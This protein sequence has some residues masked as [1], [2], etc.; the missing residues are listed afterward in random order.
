MKM[1]RYG[2]FILVL[3]CCL[4]TGCGRSKNENLDTE[5]ALASN[6]ENET[7]EGEQ[8]NLVDSDH[9]SSDDQTEDSEISGVEVEQEPLS[10]EE[11]IRQDIIE[12]SLLAEGNNYR[13][14]KVIEK[15]RNGE[16]IT[17]A[18]IGG[19]ITEGYNAGTQEIYA[20]L[21]CDYFR[22]TYATAEVTY[23][24]AGLSGTPSLLGLIRS[25]RDIFTYEPDL[26]FIEFAVND[27]QSVQDI[28]AYESLVR[29]ALSQEQEPA[30]IL[31]FSVIESGYTCQDTMQVVGFNYK[32]PMISVK[33]ALDPEFEAGR[34][35]WS[36]WS[37][38]ESHPNTFG[39]EL[40]SEFI[41]HYWNTVDQEEYDETYQL[42]DDMINMDYT[43]MIMA[44]KENLSVESTGAFHEESGHAAFPNGWVKAAEDTTEEAFT[45]EINCK[46][47][48]LVYKAANNSEYGDA[49][50]YVDGEL[51]ITISANAADGWNNPVVARI[52]RESESKTRKIE[53]RMKEGDEGK[54]FAILAFGYCP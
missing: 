4:I 37:N 27:S 44:D 29:K 14:K 22:D 13:M 45:F 43:S 15:A 41:I 48:F 18:Y 7:V 50:V 52:L 16:N 33:A 49:E 17:I 31:L 28:S 8:S 6:Q 9:T 54:Q 51:A 2:L 40:Y 11:Q 30:V 12:R 3:C 25:D 19:S 46:S 39:H 21:T 38:D 47:L 26:V 10:E 32:L 36:D 42:R 53:I 24:N 34:M 23:I 5:S 1:K 35:T 20:K